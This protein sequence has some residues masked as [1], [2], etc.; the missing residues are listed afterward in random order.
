MPKPHRAAISSTIENL[1]VNPNL[2]DILIERF[3]DNFVSFVPDVRKMRQKRK[4]CESLIEKGLA[5]ERTFELKE[6]IEKNIDKQ[7]KT[8][9][10]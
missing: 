7:F 4:I 8:K 10:C 2:T 5:T 6:T 3:C 1:D 9:R